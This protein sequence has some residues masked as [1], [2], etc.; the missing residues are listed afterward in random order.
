VIT[1]KP[2]FVDTG[3]TFGLPGLFLV[4]SPVA[5]GERIAAALEQSQDIIYVPWFW[6]YIMWIIRLLPEFI[7]KRLKL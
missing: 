3:M 1:V 7:F 5:V 4:A 6:R 2:G